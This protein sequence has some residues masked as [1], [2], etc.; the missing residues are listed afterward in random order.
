MTAALAR[1]GGERAPVETTPALLE[2]LERLIDAELGPLRAGVEPLLVE[3]RQG[4]AALHPGP[5]GQQLSPQR[6]QEQRTRLDQ[7]LDTLEDILEALQ[8][9]A[10]AQRQPGPAMGRRED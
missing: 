6:Q 8:R 4:F 10:R 7:V 5:G 9:A 3:L 2:R 1:T